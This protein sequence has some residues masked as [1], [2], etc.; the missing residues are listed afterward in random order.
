[1]KTNTLAKSVAVICNALVIVA[2]ASGV[3]HI[4][5]FAAYNYE[6]ADKYTVGDAVIEDSVK[7]LDIDWTSGNIKFEYHDED[8]VEISE[9]SRKS[10]GEDKKMRWWLDNDTLRIRFAKKGSSFFSFGFNQDKEL[11]VKLPESIALENVNIDATSGDVQIPS[12]EAQKMTIDVVSGDIS[13]DL[14]GA[15]E[16]K[17]SSVS[18]NVEAT[19]DKV[20]S[21]EIDTTS[22]DVKLSAPGLEK[23]DIDV[24]T[25]DVTA[26][27]S[28]KP[29]FT[30]HLDTV[31]GK[32]NYALPLTKESGAYVCGDG[33]GSVKIDTTTGDINLISAAE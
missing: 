4:V 8:T 25:G 33:S 27:L 18:G 5:S 10:L 22:G 12:L 20:S 9:K 29:G 26:A 24:T 31:T 15:G 14:S 32:K 19:L 1:M 30:A 13:L 17:M 23:L 21:T 16:L 11:T 7:N 3:H 6:D 2:V 28:G